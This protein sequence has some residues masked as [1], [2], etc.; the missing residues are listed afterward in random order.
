MITYTSEKALRSLRALLR[1][2]EAD[3]AVAQIDAGVWGW[4][5][6][7]HHVGRVRGL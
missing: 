6:R 7:L 5:M 1:T 2:G 4:R 3:L